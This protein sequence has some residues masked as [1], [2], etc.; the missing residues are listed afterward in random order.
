MNYRLHHIPYIVGRYSSAALTRCC[1]I[2]HTIHQHTT[3]Y[4][5]A[6]A[7]YDDVIAFLAIGNGIG[8]SLLRINIEIE[9]VCV[10][11]CC[12]YCKF[13]IDA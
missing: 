9:R 2:P 12:C 10:C 13:V 7:N 5:R 3:P 8:T 1:T 4:A 6:I 11:A